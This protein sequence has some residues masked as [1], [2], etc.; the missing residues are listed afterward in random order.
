MP[1]RVTVKNFQSIEDATLDVEAF[2]A[3][4]GPNNSGKSALFRAIFGIFSNTRGAR[5]VRNG[6][7]FCSVKIEFPDGKSV[8]WEKGPKVNR[9]YIGDRLI[10][11]VGQ[12]V[13]DEVL[14]LG[15]A[16]MEAGGRELWPQVAP[17]FDGQLFLVNQPGT[18]L[19]EALADMNR[20]GM[21]NEA[22]RLSQSDRRTQSGELKV[23][24]TDLLKLE[25]NLT[26]YE[27]LDTV[28]ATVHD[29]EGLE[30]IHDSLAQEFE[31][32][33]GVKDRREMA[34]DVLHSL[35]GVRLLSIPSQEVLCSKFDGLSEDVTSVKLLRRR[36]KDIRVILT[37]LGGV[38]ELSLDVKTEDRT[39][40]LA[41]AVEFVT[42]LSA[43]WDRAKDDLETLQSVPDPALPS[44]QEFDDPRGKNTLLVDTR[45][46]KTRLAQVRST[47]KTALSEIEQV[48]S[49][50]D[51][52]LVE[53]RSI[54]GEAQ[55]CPVCGT[56]TKHE[57]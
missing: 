17:Q 51:G 9:Y 50:Y 1:F 12:T 55:E 32:V 56:V 15:I 27:G 48:H 36:L 44:K 28:L 49:E 35:D 21:L 38:R 29:A 16:P 6:A 4:T 46:L 41:T 40:K 54:L 7:D 45:A 2:T 26:S 31:T 18:V 22:L 30:K 43:R 33:R 13:P 37:S 20:V 52:L 5:F 14:E 11:K 53:I 3:V 39:K 42:S 57:E 10:D 19:A 47:I 25:S 8:T 24:E 34:L 23:R